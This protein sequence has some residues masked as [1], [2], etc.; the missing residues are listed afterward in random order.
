MI[1]ET[2]KQIAELLA[3]D[4]TLEMEKQLALPKMMRKLYKELG[5]PNLPDYPDIYNHIGYVDRIGGWTKYPIFLQ[6]AEMKRMNSEPTDWR[7]KRPSS[8]K[9]RIVDEYIRDGWHCRVQAYNVL[10]GKFVKHKDYDNVWV[11]FMSTRDC[12]KFEY[13]IVAD[14]E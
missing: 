5:K 10:C 1:N 3:S 7:V 6:I 8:T 2:A 9:C 12:S 13:V 14:G 11:H 4:S